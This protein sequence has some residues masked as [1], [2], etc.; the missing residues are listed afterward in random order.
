MRTPIP[1]CQKL[2]PL[3]EPLAAA[4]AANA[5]NPAID[6]VDETAIGGQAAAETRNISGGGGGRRSGREDRGEGA[7]GGRQDSQLRR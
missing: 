1:T 6:A 2:R 7:F 4:A 5:E 3:P